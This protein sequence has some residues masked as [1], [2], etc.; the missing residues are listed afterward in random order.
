MGA[1]KSSKKYMK[2]TVSSDIELFKIVDLFKVGKLYIIMYASDPHEIANFVMRQDDQ[3][4]YYPENHMGRNV[5]MVYFSVPYKQ[6]VL[7]YS[8]DYTPNKVCSL[9]MMIKNK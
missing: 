3:D 6:K 5:G 7:Y 2:T 1:S 8:G 4:Y 9:R